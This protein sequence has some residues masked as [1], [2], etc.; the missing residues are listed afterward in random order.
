MTHGVRQ[1][2]RFNWPAY[3]AAAALALIGMLVVQRLT[4]SGGT[5]ALLLIGPAL[6]T[7]WLA[8]SLLASWIVYDRSRLMRWDWIGEA[9]DSPARSWINLHCG[10][11]ESTGALRRLFHGSSGRVFDIFDPAEMTEPSIR[12]ARALA[13]NQIEPE[14]VSFRCLPAGTGSVDAA[15]LLM[16]AHELRSPAARAALF[17]EIHR[18]L[19]P[20]GRVV[21]AEHLRNWANLLAFGPGFLHFH[22]RGT[23]RRCFA[24]ARL[25]VRLEFPI[26]PFV[27][28]FI[29]QR[30]R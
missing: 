11:D 15:L 9:L 13:R 14:P 29:L 8:S 6:A 16:S 17:G 7:F 4:I 28:V 21:V 3:A 26:T 10:F 22:S 20:G 2:V 24:A 19:A 12:R 1:I 27:R 25:T 23:W 5:R 30:D 18:L